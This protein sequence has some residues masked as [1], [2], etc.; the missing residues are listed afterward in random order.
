MKLRNSPHSITWTLSIVRSH[1]ISDFKHQEVILNTLVYKMLRHLG[2]FSLSH[3]CTK[4]LQLLTGTPC[5]KISHSAS[6]FCYFSALLIHS[7]HFSSLENTPAVIPLYACATVCAYLL[8]CNYHGVFLLSHFSSLF[9]R[10]RESQCLIFIIQ[11]VPLICYLLFSRIELRTLT[12]KL[13]ILR[14]GE[15]AQ[16]EKSNVYSQ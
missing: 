1:D 5:F 16:L 11:E 9:I 4:W 15:Y 10:Q 13:S 2:S 8:S 3:L 14:Y 12:W 7:S 6:L